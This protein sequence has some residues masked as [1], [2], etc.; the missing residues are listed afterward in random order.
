MTQNLLQ[1]QTKADTPPSYLSEY[2]RDAPGIFVTNKRDNEEERVARI[3]HVLSRLT[4]SQADAGRILEESRRMWAN[5]Q[6]TRERR[7]KIVE[8][9]RAALK[10]KP[11]TKKTSSRRKKS[12]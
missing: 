6:S 11:A 5:L 2:D 1:N 3:E 9:V 7:A 12:R 10:P 8:S 4:D